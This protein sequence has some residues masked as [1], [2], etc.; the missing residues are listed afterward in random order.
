MNPDQQP[1]EKLEILPEAVTTNEYAYKEEQPVLPPVEEHAE[2]MGL[3]LISVSTALVL[4]IITAILWTT[5]KVDTDAAGEAVQAYAVGAILLFVTLMFVTPI[6]SIFS[7]ITGILAYKRSRA[8]ARYVAIGSFVIT[9]AGIVM[10]MLFV[11]HIQN[12]QLPT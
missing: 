3:A 7:I 11:N 9:V 4:P 6:T 10:V 12:P 5:I 2:Q 8:V 1:E